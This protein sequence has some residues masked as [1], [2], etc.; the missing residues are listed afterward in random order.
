[1][2]AAR[3]IDV[4]MS[5]SAGSTGSALWR[6]IGL[7][8]DRVASRAATF[9]HTLLRRRTAVVLHSPSMPSLAETRLHALVN[10]PS[11]GSHGTDAGCLAR[12]LDYRIIIM[13][14]TVTVQQVG[15]GVYGIDAETLK[16]AVGSST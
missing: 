1:M 7:A 5:G 13:L 6:T 15:A 16:T 8:A 2:W 11:T 9:M 10:D 14:Q 12:A 4:R 3:A